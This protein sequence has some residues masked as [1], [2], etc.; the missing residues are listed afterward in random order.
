MVHD[1][2]ILVFFLF[3]L[4]IL[5]DLRIQ[6]QSKKKCLARPSW[7]RMNRYAYINHCVVSVVA[8]QDIA[9]CYIA[10][11]ALGNEEEI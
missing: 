4:M 6:F 10:H 1:V 9:M 5:F 7:I 2:I 11:Q 3:G 8:W